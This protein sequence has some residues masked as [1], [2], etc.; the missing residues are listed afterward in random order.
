[1][2]LMTDTVLIILLI[3]L[4]SPILL[5]GYT[6]ITKLRTKHRNQKID[7]QRRKTFKIV[8]NK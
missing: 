8:Q 7:E 6:S 4:S 2:K 3:A 1:M 5:V